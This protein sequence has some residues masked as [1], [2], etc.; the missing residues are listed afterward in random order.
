M[1]CRRRDRECDASPGASRGRRHAARGLDR[2]LEAR[3]KALR[4]SRP[5]VPANS[6]RRRPATH[7]PTSSGSRLA[8]GSSR[9]T[10]AWSVTRTPPQ[11]GD[12]LARPAYV[13]AQ[14]SEH[15]RERR[16]LECRALAQWPSAERK[17]TTP[18]G[19]TR[20][21]SLGTTSVPAIPDSRI[22][23]DAPTSFAAS[24]P[25]SCTTTHRAGGGSSRVRLRSAVRGVGPGRSRIG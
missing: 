1:F 9:S 12:Q 6:T 7:R 25:I 19:A 15:R 8:S 2:L 3:V 16:L 20:M 21:T 18:E 11:S 5:T 14:P 17:Q 23:R 10:H 24:R 22:A 13:A 4:P